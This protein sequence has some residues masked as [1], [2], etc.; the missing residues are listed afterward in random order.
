MAV[1]HI[2]KHLRWPLKTPTPIKITNIQHSRQGLLGL[3]Y[4]VL[5]FHKTIKLKR[6]TEPFTITKPS[7]NIN[8][9]T[10]KLKGHSNPVLP[11]HPS[12]K[13]IAMRP[14]PYK[15]D[16]IRLPFIHNNSHAKECH[17]WVKTWNVI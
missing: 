13:R 14:P 17:K 8:T 6:K 16:K 10:L 9:S 2:N 15:F 3:W 7:P 1:N 11:N 4:R 5:G 12:H